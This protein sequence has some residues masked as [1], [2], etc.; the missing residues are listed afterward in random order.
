MLVAKPVCSIFATLPRQLILTLLLAS[1]VMVL[2]GCLSSGRDSS[3]EDGGSGDSTGNSEGGATTPHPM[4]KSDRDKVTEAGHL[5]ALE[6]FLVRLKDHTSEDSQSEAVAASFGGSVVGS[7]CSLTLVHF[8]LPSGSLEETPNI[9]D[10]LFEPDFA[11]RPRRFDVST[12]YPSSSL[13]V[14]NDCLHFT[15]RPLRLSF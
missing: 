8:K 12:A 14:A 15:R 5:I 10:S 1:V 7:S 6:L 3:S 9:A 2:R 4:T 11:E 13:R